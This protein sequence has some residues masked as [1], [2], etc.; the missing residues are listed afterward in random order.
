VKYSKGNYKYVTR[1]RITYQYKYI[2]PIVDI[3][4]KSASGRL[5]A[6]LTADGFLTVE[7]AYAY[8]G[9]SGPT[10]DTPNSIFPSLIHDVPF[11]LMR[12]GKLDRA[13]FH[14]A[15]LD[16]RDALRD[17]GMT[18]LRSWLWYKGVETKAAYQST[19]AK[20]EPEILWTP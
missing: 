20:N 15:N 12:L 19:L 5:L 16:F 1:E 18:T 9:P 2:R 8:D 7:E 3:E 11:Q 14:N 4:I 10:V 13:E 17:R 6:S